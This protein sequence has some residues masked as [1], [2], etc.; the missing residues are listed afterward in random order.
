LE[1]R[2]FEYRGTLLLISH[3]RAFINNVVTSTIVFEGN[4]HVVEYAGGY[5]DWLSQRP[6]GAVERLPVKNS[7]KKIRPKP[8]TRPSRKLGY[9]QQREM[10]D[11]PQKIEA[12]ESEQKELFG[13]LADPGFYKKGKDEIAGV[14]SNLDRIEREI[15]TAY[16]RWQE[17]EALNSQTNP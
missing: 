16:R 10:Q 15:E 17:L 11:L 14:K 7:R 12:L 8:K 13:I 5:D 9:I 2:I 4:G 1:E 3:D 6:Q